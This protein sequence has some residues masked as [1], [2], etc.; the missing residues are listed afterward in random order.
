MRTLFPLL[1]CAACTGGFGAVELVELDEAPEQLSELNLVRVDGEGA[2][3]LNDRVEPY[4]LNTP[5]F[6]DYALKERHIYVPEGQAAAPDPRWTYDFPVGSAILKTFVVV[7]DLRDTETDRRR[8]ETRVLV[9][10][11]QE[12]VAWPYIWNDEGTDAVFSPSG[13]T[14]ADSVIDRNGEA[15]DF[16]YLVP[17]KNQCQECHEI[18]D[19]TTGEQGIVP[20]G[21]TIRNMH[22]VHDG[23]DQL[24]HLVSAGLLQAAAEKPTAAVDWKAVRDTDWTTVD[25]ATLNATARDYLDVNCA[26]CHNERA[27]NGETSQLFLSW[28]NADRFRLG[29]C[30]KPGSAAKGT[31]GFRYDIVPGNP[32]ESILHYRMRTDEIGNMMPDIGRSLVHDEGLALIGE[33]I[34]R[35][36]DPPCSDE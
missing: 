15:R 7:P 26:H 19:S 22:G 9:R 12:W 1:L 11:A 21:P 33:W 23:Q 31:G 29:L 34:R 36:D 2:L 6:S 14:I 30:K 18:A 28:D 8:V 32:E 13:A 17:Q 27:V 20:I 5:L 24:E 16:T 25:D 3:L 35:M 10:Q 4:S